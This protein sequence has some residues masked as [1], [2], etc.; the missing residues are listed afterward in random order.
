MQCGGKFQQNNFF[1][2][3]SYSLQNTHSFLKELYLKWLEI[4]ERVG[5]MAVEGELE[6]WHGGLRALREFRVMTRSFA[7]DESHQNVNRGLCE[8]WISSKCKYGTFSDQVHLWIRNQGEC[9]SIFIN[10]KTWVYK[11]SIK[12]LLSTYINN[13]TSIYYSIRYTW[14]TC[15]KC[16]GFIES[17]LSSMQYV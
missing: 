4:G 16:I 2:N 14:W 13:D 8:R 5:H 9:A 3:W 15:T 7:S 11:S 17:N 12:Y 6:L 1:I 10:P